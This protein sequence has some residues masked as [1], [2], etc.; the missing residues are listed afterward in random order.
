MD[1]IPVLVG[2]FFY[3][4]IVKP[5]WRQP[6]RGSTKPGG[7]I[8]HFGLG[9][10]FLAIGLGVLSGHILFLPPAL[11][12]FAV[13]WVGGILDSLSFPAQGSEFKS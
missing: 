11:I 13:A 4:C 12:G 1:I 6:W 10:F 5:E 3:A 2:V 8:W 7:A 9:T